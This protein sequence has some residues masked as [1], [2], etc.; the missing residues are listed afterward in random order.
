MKS[1][2]TVATG[3]LVLFAGGVTACP[4]MDGK[5]NTTEYDQQDQTHQTLVENEVEIIDPE[6]LAKLLLLEKEREIN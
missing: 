1:L 5:Q 2:L 3:I 6:L 4:L